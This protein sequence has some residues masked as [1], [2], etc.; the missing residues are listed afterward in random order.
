MYADNGRGGGSTYFNIDNVKIATAW[1]YADGG[2]MTFLLPAVKNQ[3][4]TTNNTS[5]CS[6]DF[7]YGVKR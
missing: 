4:I 2:Q 5:N 1:E 7:V 3:I 6:I